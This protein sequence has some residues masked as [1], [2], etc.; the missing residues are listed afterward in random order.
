MALQESWKFQCKNIHTIV[1]IHV[2]IIIATSHILE[3]G[4]LS[5]GFLDFI[6]SHHNFTF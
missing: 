2:A 6:N 5:K 3:V 4:P 1:T